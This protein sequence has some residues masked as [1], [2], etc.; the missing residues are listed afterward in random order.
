MYC[1]ILDPRRKPGAHQQVAG[2]GSSLW[3]CLLVLFC[4][5]LLQF[6]KL[7][8]RDFLL[9]IQNLKVNVQQ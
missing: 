9:L 4:Q 5:T 1:D 7:V 2:W 3:L 6:A 8:Q